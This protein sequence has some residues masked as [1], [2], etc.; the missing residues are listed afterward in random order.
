YKKFSSKRAEIQTSFSNVEPKKYA[1]ASANTGMFCNAFADGERKDAPLVET[2]AFKSSDMRAKKESETKS[3][4]KVMKNPLSKAAKNLALTCADVK[5]SMAQN[6]APISAKDVF[7]S[8][9]RETNSRPNFSIPALAKGYKSGDMIDLSHKSDA[10]LRAIQAL[11]AKPIAAEDPN[12]SKKSKNKRALERIKSK[13]ATE[14]S[15]SDAPEDE[16]DAEDREERRAKKMRADIISKALSRKSVNE[17]GVEKAEAMATEKY[18]STLEK[19]E[20][21]E[22]KLSET[23]HDC[24]YTAHSA[25]ELCKKSGHKLVRHKATKRFFKCKN[26]KNRSYTFNLL[27]PAKACSKC[28]ELS[29][30]KAS[31][32]HIKEET[33]LMDKKLQIRGEEIKFI[34]SLR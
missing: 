34:N 21:M 32:V 22:T 25:S 31:V 12:D 26:C 8:V 14:L 17:S 4:S 16:A 29:Y 2:K 9:R 18:F 7:N 6:S 24:K 3:L 15:A 11:K 13:I 30:A 19:K 27:L 1:T 20:K 10:K 33:T 23:C 5:A 28:G